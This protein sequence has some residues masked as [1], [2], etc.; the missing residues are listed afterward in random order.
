MSL[1]KEHAEELFLRALCFFVFAAFIVCTYQEPVVPEQ[2]AL[3][4]EKLGDYLVGV[5][6]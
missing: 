3:V 4:T 1:F 5:G 2:A 6:Y